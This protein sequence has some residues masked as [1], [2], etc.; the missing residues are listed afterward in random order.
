MA[1]ETGIVKE[2]SSCRLAQDRV[3]KLIAN[4]FMFARTLRILA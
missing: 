1:V 2:E 4:F 3:S